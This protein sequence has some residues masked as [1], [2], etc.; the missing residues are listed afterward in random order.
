[1]TQALEVRLVSHPTD[2][3]RALIGELNEELGTLYTPEQRHGLAL[4]AIFR[5]HIRFFVA[6]RGSEPLGCGGVAFFAGF[7]E[8][9]RMYVRPAARG[10]GVADAVMAALSVEAINAGLPV[11]RLETG[12]HQQAALAFYRRC[13]FNDC[14]AFPPYS[15]MPPAAIITSV[16]MERRLA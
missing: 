11:L 13:G 10:Q 7:A 12:I 16:F 2:E 1:M 8:V 3:V 6:W 9:K 4:E 5:P 14:G 15:E